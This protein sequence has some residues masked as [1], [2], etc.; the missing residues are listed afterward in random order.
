MGSGDNHMT[1]AGVQVANGCETAGVQ[2]AGALTLELCVHERT[3]QLVVS[4]PPH[5]H[6]HSHPCYGCM[7]CNLT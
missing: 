3:G 7:L 2:V 4:P 5:T 1:T 6:T